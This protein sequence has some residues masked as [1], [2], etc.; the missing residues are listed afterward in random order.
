MQYLDFEL[1]VRKGKGR[2][3]RYEVAARSATEGG[4]EGTMQF[5]FSAAQLDAHLMAIENSLLR[6][7]Q[8]GV[9]R[10]SVPTLR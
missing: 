3:R 2:G 5:P 9:A 1:T 4:V 8:P 10:V 7:S 6:A